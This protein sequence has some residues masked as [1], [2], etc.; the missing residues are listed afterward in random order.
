MVKVRHLL[1]QLV[2]SRRQRFTAIQ[3]AGAPPAPPG[4]SRRC[5]RLAL[6]AVADRAVAGVQ[7]SEHE[8][9][10]ERVRMAPTAT[11][12][13]RSSRL[14]QASFAAPHDAARRAAETHCVAGHIRP[15]LRYPLGSKNARVAAGSAGDLAETAP[16][17]LFAF[18]LR[19]EECGLKNM[20]Q[21]KGFPLASQKAER[22][23]SGV[24]HMLGWS[25]SNS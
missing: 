19:L 1:D 21:R 16:Q 13:E 9:V 20:Q 15:E 8:I 12:S 5:A 3:R 22:R 2:E 7:L 18:E 23:D 17:R 4:S 10:A 6:I 14:P 25:D 24:V 11:P